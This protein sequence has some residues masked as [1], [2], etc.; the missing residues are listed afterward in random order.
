M[1]YI[2]EGFYSKPQEYYITEEQSTDVLS[3]A[4]FQRYFQPYYY[5]VKSH[6]RCFLCAGDFNQNVNQALELANE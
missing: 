3:V 1:R 2:R 5:A 6:L 4:S